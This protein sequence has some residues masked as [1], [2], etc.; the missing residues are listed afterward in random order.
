M[1]DLREANSI[2][3]DIGGNPYSV[4]P[5]GRNACCKILCKFILKQRSPI[6]SV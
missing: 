4:R 3:N 1:L 6:R 5:F 2:D